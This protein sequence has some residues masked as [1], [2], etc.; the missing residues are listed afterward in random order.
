MGLGSE[1]FLV[2]LA[3]ML[4][5]IITLVAFLGGWIVKIGLR[6]GR[7]GEANTRA[8][9]LLTSEVRFL[10]EKIAPLLQMEKTVAV[11][12]EWRKNGRHK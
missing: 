4:S 11:L 6:G 1:T 5:A 2:I 9:L 3:A 8:I 7:S 10:N 12:E